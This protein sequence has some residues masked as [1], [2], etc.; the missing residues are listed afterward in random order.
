MFKLHHWLTDFDEMILLNFMVRESIEFQPPKKKK[1]N[2]PNTKQRGHTWS[3][4][5]G[6][7]L[8][9]SVVVNGD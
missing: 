8:E 9:V 6:H 2:P 3:V 5:H 1:K 4:R 7:E